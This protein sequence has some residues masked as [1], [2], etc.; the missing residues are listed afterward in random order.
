MDCMADSLYIW[1]YIYVLLTPIHSHRYL[2][3]ISSNVAFVLLNMVIIKCLNKEND[4]N[5]S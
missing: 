5:I 3:P 1:F 2:H 4:N